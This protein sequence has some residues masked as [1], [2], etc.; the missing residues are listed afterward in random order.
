MSLPLNGEVAP[1]DSNRVGKV[2]V[3]GETLVFFYYVAVNH[4]AA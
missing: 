4:F 1:S 2:A 3:N